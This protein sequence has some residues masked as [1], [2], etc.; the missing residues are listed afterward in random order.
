MK[1]QS[2]SELYTFLAA[3]ALRDARVQHFFMGTIE[4]WLDYQKENAQY[5]CVYAWMPEVD[6]GLNAAR[7]KPFISY[8]LTL[9]VHDQP[10]EKTDRWAATAQSE[11]V[12]RTLLKRLYMLRAKGIID[13]LEQPGDTNY[14]PFAT[15]DGTVGWDAPLIIG[16][17]TGSMCA[18][19]VRPVF[20]V[21]VE[22]NADA[23]VLELDVNGTGI[24]IDWDGQ[25]DTLPVAL[26]TLRQALEAGNYA[27]MQIWDTPNGLVIYA[28]TSGVTIEPVAG[29]FR[30]YITKMAAFEE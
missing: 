17:Y 27:N 25:P 29:P 19:R 3:Q 11:D 13:Q 2:V 21:T 12:M 24:E 18:E 28:G 26:Y 22:A 8:L 14:A 30:H 10:T 5:P 4:Q 15:P 20:S 16:T 1:I 23:T 7:G 6:M 9:E